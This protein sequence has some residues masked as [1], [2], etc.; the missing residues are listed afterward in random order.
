VLVIAHRGFSA[1]A[2]ENTLPAFRLALQTAADLVELDYYHSADEQPVVFHDK[3]L[4]RTTNAIQVLGREKIP[5]TSLTLQQ[6]RRLDAGSW[7]DQEFQDT[8]I[9]T[10][11]EALGVIQQKS[12]TLIERK[13]GDAAT[14]VRLLRDKRLLHHVVVQ[15][16]DWS[17]LR[18]CHRLAPELVLG[19]LGSKP[20][21]S[22]HVA[23]IQQ[24]GASVVGWSE[25]DL[26]PAAIETLHQY[27][28]KV[29]SYT[30]ND[31]TRAS[32]LIDWGIDGIITDDPLTIGRA[33]RNG[34]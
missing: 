14:C 15:A 18:E 2:P 12:T 23:E 31:A 11:A 22:E 32:E 26:S 4:D 13:H 19:A 28:L 33:V 9:P 5:V 29:W 16:F 3:E 25:Q 17:Y 8:R 20:M 7:F 10:L 24:S 21:S 1:R 6:L 30:V 34:R 27:G